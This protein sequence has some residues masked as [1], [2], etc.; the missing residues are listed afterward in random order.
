MRCDQDA[1]LGEAAATTSRDGR[2]KKFV[3][4]KTSVVILPTRLV[5]EQRELGIIPN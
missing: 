4:S 5:F 3:G 1:S 2:S